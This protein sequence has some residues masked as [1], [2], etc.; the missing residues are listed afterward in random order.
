MKTVADF[1]DFLKTLPQDHELMVD[2]QDSNCPED[3]QSIEE[4]MSEG[5]K[6]FTIDSRSLKSEEKSISQKFVV[7]NMY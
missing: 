7:L 1:I 4:A 3:W 6:V 5:I 2:C